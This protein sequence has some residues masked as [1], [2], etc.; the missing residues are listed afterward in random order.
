MTELI[1][2]KKVLVI[3]YYWPPAGGIG[4]HRCLKFVKYL[5]KYGWEPIVYAPENAQY[6]YFDEGNYKD[7]PENL[8]IIKRP[9][10][11]PF[12]MFKIL[13]GRGK[14]SSLSNPLFV[15]DKKKKFVD[16]LA[17]WIRGNFF[18]PDARSLWIKP[19]VKYLAEYIKQNNV[20]A[21]FSDGPP[22]TNTVIACKLSQKFGIPWL[23][24]FQDP[25]TQVDYYEHF[26]LTSWADRKHKKMEQ[27]V[28][29]TAKKITIASPSWKYDIETIGAKNVDV[30]FWGYDEDDF[31]DLK[32]SVTEKFIITHSGLLGLDRSP[33]TFLKVIKKKIEENSLF[34]EKVL[35]K[36]IGMVDYSIIDIINKLELNEYLFMPGNVSRKESLEHLSESS[37]LLLPLNKAKNAKG[38]IPG[39][40]FECLRMNIP[41][42]CLGRK[43][44]DSAYI[45]ESTKRGKVFEYDDFDNIEKYV[46]YLFTF[47][48]KRDK[49]ESETD[50]SEYSVDNQTKKLAG[51]L[52]E[53]IEEK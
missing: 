42:L 4:V 49:T 34:K 35:L 13:S 28:F 38:R 12:N 14:E 30:L 32:K 6:P 7:I 5:R 53:I 19:S 22:H 15:R 23:A 10:I 2:R 33:E 26:R 52:D 27:E 50:I 48:L 51:F 1:N 37:I 17:I 21:I 36:F 44:S 45:I 46:D 11:E 18:I 25:W 29:K 47:Y 39:K 3:S 40:L 9:I 16:E 43:D 41:V 24:D 20:D 31:T 8:T